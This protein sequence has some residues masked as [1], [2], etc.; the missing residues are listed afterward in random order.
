MYFFRYL[1]YVISQSSGYPQFCLS[2]STPVSVVTKECINIQNLGTLTH[3]HI[4]SAGVL[5]KPKWGDLALCVGAIPEQCK[6]Y[7]FTFSPFRL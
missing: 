7:R 3:M 4:Q 1:R 2:H 6:P 5:L